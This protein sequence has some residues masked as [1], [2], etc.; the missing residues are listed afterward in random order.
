MLYEK[1][2]DFLVDGLRQ[3]LRLSLIVE[4]TMVLLRKWHVWVVKRKGEISVM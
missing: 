1:V 3:S 4:G 2:A